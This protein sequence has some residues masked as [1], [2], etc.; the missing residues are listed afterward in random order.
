M[1]SNTRSPRALGMLLLILCNIGI[2]IAQTPPVRILPLGDSITF[3]TGITTRQGGYRNQ[4]YQLLT[5]SGYQVDFVG[6][7]TDSNNPTLPDRNHEGNG[8]FRIDQIQAGVS[9]WLD[10]IEDPDVILLLI[11][12]NDFSQKYNIQSAGTRLSNLIGDLAVKRPFARIVV[13]TLPPRTDDAALETQQLS[14]NAS[15]PGI[16][17][18]QVALGRH[19]SHVNMHDSLAAGDLSDGV[20]PNTPG[21]DKMATVW[22]PAITGVITP[23]G[24]SDPPAIVRINR[25]DDFT[26]VSIRF[27]KPL[28]DSAATV[29]NF[30][31]SGGLA[32]SQ[33]TLDSESKRIITLTTSLQTS[34][35]RYTLTVNGVRDRTPQQN[36]IAPGS[37]IDFST[38]G[39][40]N[41]SFENDFAGWTAT[42]NAVIAGSSPYTATEGGKLVVFNG[43]EST[44]SGQITQTF[45][46]VSGTSYRLTFDVGVLAYNTR[47]QQLQISVNGASPI[48][49]QSLTI[50]GTANGVAR[51]FPQQFLFTANSPSTTLA[52]RDVSAT[53]ASLDLLLDNAQITAL[54]SSGL[55]NLAVNS[56]PNGGVSINVTPADSN[57]SSNGG[58]SFSRSYTDGTTVNLSAPATSGGLTFSKWQRNGSDFATSAATSVPMTTDLTMTAVYEGTTPTQQIVVNGSFESGLASWASSGNVVVQ[59]GSPYAPSD[60]GTLIVFNGGNSTPNG[61]ISQTVPTTPGKT[62]TLD[63]DLGVFSYNTAQQKMLVRVEGSGN[64]LNQTLTLARSGGSNVVWTPRTYTFVANSATSTLSFTDVS[65]ATASLDLTLD[66]VR[67]TGEAP[68]QVETLVTNGSFESG[69]ANWNATGSSNTV[70]VSTSLPA[71]DGTTL[72]QFNGGNSPNDGQVSQVVQTSPGTTYQV[73]FD[74]GVLA[75]NTNNQTLRFRAEGNGILSTQFVTLK[76]TGG[77]QVQWVSRN[78]T[79]TANSTTTALNFSDISTTTLGLDLLLD[80]VRLSLAPAA[81]VIDGGPAEPIP[82]ASLDQPVTLV[83][84]G[85][86]S[87]ITMIA[88]SPGR[89]FLERS[90]DLQSW[91]FQ[92][93]VTL[94]EAGPVEFE[95]ADSRADRMFYRIG[96]ETTAD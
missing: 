36:L 92:S 95:D 83:R 7:K 14:F 25:L 28:A 42:G 8:G 45:A 9:G 20:H 62:Y 16:V 11:G 21:Y 19:V 34:G 50:N 64:L 85:A 58:T 73:N 82:L 4:L 77:G 76:G 3:G 65:T 86:G 39:L 13:S 90:E 72:I 53:T 6:T 5:N 61:V 89:Y 17:S 88:T 57:G 23:L 69:L 40:N 31:L 48:L 15:I 27:S 78:F 93:E 60:G 67:I 49:T 18:N 66:R 55:R 2:G 26:K 32:I 43:G 81:L 12:T 84:N 74:V 37:S 54:A 71:T 1:H 80:H 33:A 96:H 79:F 94:T 68:P 22:H 56:S 41:G 63:F 75:Y 51:W 47:Q 52:F 29:S 70:F 30:S 87:R 44:P 46:T 91:V 35:T 10:S 59:S 38:Q 24:T